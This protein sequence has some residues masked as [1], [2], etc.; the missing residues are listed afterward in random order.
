MKKCPYCAEVVQDNAIK[1]KHCN[2]W[3]YIDKKLDE[4]IAKK[5]G[6]LIT[7]P[8][9]KLGRLLLLRKLKGVVRG[10]YVQKGYTLSFENT[11]LTWN[12]GGKTYIW[13]YRKEK[14]KPE[15]FVDGVFLALHQG[16]I[17]S[18]VVQLP[19]VW[20]D[21]YL[22][23][24]Q[25][26]ATM[27]VCDLKE[28]YGKGGEEFTLLEPIEVENKYMYGSMFC[29]ETID[30]ITGKKKGFILRAIFPAKD[31]A[32][33]ITAY[34]PLQGL[35]KVAFEDCLKIFKSFTWEL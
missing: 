17:I 34:I 2:E 5:E 22:D 4:E 29:G 24:P 32:I 20:K 7:R 23:R 9:L 12:R 28:R 33:V 16:T 35:Y 13:S 18:V 15:A 11:K 10:T 31:V 6:N 26:I 1:C 19:P 14:I 25:D 8:I 27:L 21:E 30:K 3:L